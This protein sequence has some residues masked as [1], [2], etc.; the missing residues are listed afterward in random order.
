MVKAPVLAGPQTITDAD[1]L[2]SLVVVSSSV[3]PVPPSVTVA[4]LSYS[5][6]VPLTTET[7][8]V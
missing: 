3:L 5:V 2:S 7:E 8:R 4:V 6:Q 1:E